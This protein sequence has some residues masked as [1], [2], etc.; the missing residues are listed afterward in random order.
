MQ[1]SVFHHFLACEFGRRGLIFVISQ[2]FVL[3]L[4]IPNLMG[5]HK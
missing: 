4:T 5:G 1:N 2:N 3:L